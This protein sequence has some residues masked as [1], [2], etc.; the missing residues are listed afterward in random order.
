MS[1]CAGAGRKHSQTDSLSCSMEIFY[2]I[3]ITLSL[4]MA[5]GGGR[6]EGISSSLVQVF[7]HFF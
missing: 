7:K 1:R 4:L 5:I 3:D 2:T 6:E